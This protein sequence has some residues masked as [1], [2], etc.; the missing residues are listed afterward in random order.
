MNTKKTEVFKNGK[1]QNKS[2]IFK[3]NLINFNSF[4]ISLDLLN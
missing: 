2:S 1:T 4:K 3:W